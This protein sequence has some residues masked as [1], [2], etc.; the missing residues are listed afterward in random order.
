MS[1]IFPIY[2]PLIGEAE[3]NNVIDC[4]NST[5]ISSIGKYIDKFKN[6]FSEFINVKYSISVCNVAVAFHLVLNSLG[7][8]EGDE[9]IVP[10]LTY[11]AL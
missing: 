5:W 9:V 7:I 3:K 8:G 6:K 10:T 4:I 11:I 1:I 2:K